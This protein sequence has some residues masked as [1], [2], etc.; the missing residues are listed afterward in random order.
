PRPSPGG[1]GR[2]RRGV[3]LHWV[4]CGHCGT[5]SGGEI[6]RKLLGECPGRLVLRAETVSGSLG[7]SAQARFIDREHGPVFEHDVA[8]HEDCIDISASLGVDESVER[9]SEGPEK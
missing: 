8:I 9:M 1:R 7:L 4:W 3:T 5:T 6:G 2:L